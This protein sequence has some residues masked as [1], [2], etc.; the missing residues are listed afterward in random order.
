MASDYETYRTQAE[1]EA[2]LAMEA[3]TWPHAHV[4]RKDLVRGNQLCVRYV[5]ACDRATD[6]QVRR[7]LRSDGYVR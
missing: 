4:E 1:A 6:P 7:Y 2:A 3:G 5:I